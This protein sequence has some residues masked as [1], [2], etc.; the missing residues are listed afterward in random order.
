MATVR[1]GYEK[2]RWMAEHGQ[3]EE[4]I[5]IVFVE[6]EQKERIRNQK[7]KQNFV[8]CTGD[9]DLCSEFEREKDRI[10]RRVQNKTLMLELMVRAWREALSDGEIDRIMARMEGPES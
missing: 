9:P 6:Q 2:L 7:R 8:L 5:H 1:Q 4:K 10:F 3:G